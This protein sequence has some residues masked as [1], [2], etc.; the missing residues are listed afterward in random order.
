VTPVTDI[1]VH[2]QDLAISTLGRSFWILDDISTLHELDPGTHDLQVLNLRTILGE[3]TI[4]N[5]RLPAD[6]DNRDSV[7]FEISRGPD[8]LLSKQL[9]LEKHPAGQWGIRT[10]PWDQRYYYNRNVRP[11][12]SGQSMPADIFSDTPFKGPLVAPSDLT[13]SLTYRGERTS[14]TFTFEMHPEWIQEGMTVLDLK[15]QEALSV[16]IAQL[17]MEIKAKKEAL[18]TQLKEKEDPALRATLAQLKKGPA[19]YDKPMIYDQ[20]KYLYEMITH[21]PQKPGDEAHARYAVLKRM[22]E[23]MRL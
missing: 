6:A 22:W 16:R 5:F 2:R 1:N 23:E 13:V 11:V 18:E 3:K 21:V 14:R 15:E 10:M 7:L 17:Y 20:V 8:V 12:S 4:F 9:K 19:R